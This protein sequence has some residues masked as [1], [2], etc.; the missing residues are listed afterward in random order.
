MSI[1]KTLRTLNKEYIMAIK[2]MK[3]NNLTNIYNMSS[4]ELII[5]Y[6]LWIIS[7]YIFNNNDDIYTINNFIQFINN[8]DDIIDN[9][10]FIIYNYMYENYIR[11][12]F[13]EN[14]YLFC[15]NLLNKK[16]YNY[17]YL[18][19]VKNHIYDER[20][21]NTKFNLHNTLVKNMSNLIKDIWVK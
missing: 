17:E 20:F 5:F 10:K 2:W 21:L 6:N 11:Y 12:R 4:L 1:L 19:F 14:V 15:I 9:N 3:K 18:T 16:K 13:G 8:I 7:Y